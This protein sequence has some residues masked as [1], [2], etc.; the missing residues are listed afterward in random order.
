MQSPKNRQLVLENVL[1]FLKCLIIQR[2]CNIWFYWI[3]ID[4]NLVRLDIFCSSE[5]S[6]LLDKDGGESQRNKLCLFIFNQGK[7]FLF[8]DC[9][10]WSRF[11]DTNTQLS[12]ETSPN[13][14]IK[15]I[16]IREI[17]INE[18]FILILY[19]VLTVWHSLN[20]VLNWEDIFGFLIVG[21]CILSWQR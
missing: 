21:S 6:P 9:L 15:S 10:L 17:N 14:V 2:A 13:I 1:F 19:R 20:F 11:G 3:Y 12:S 8:Q 18:H 16:L 4:N 5:Y 7:I